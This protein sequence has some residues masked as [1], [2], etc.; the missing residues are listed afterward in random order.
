[1]VKIRLARIGRKNLA[2]YRVVAVD[3]E[4]KRN[5]K[6]IEELGT[7]NPHSK[8]F[9]VEAERVKYWLSVGAQPTETVARQL[10]KAGLLDES[11]L[12]KKTFNAEPGQKAQDR[13]AAKEAPSK[14]EKPIE[15]NKSPED[16]AVKEVAE[17]K[18]ATGETPDK[19]ESKKEDDAAPEA[20]TCESKE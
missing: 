4:K 14:E 6:F 10:V 7:F 18:E 1:M 12:E 11:K 13:K 2:T 20:D 19:A 15:A 16:K 17:K 8:E 9:K 3:S 5:T